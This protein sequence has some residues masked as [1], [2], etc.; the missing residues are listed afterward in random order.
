M[1]FIEEFLIQLGVFDKIIYL[2]TLISYIQ[3]KDLF[4]SKLSKALI[5]TSFSTPIEI[6]LMCLFM[7]FYD[8]I[9]N[10]KKIILVAEELCQNEEGKVKNSSK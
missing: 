8:L 7:S 3:L 10:L 1:C 2:L 9:R 4:D 6:N 5:N